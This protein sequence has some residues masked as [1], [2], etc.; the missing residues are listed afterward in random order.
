MTRLPLRLR[1]TATYVALLVVVLALVLGSSW[2]LLHRH[3]ERTLP[4][5]YVDGVME[6]LGS[7]YLLALLGAG[8]LA[9]GVGWAVA[10]SALAPLRRIAQVAR[11]VSDEDLSARVRMEDAPEDEVRELAVAFDAMLDRVAA[12]VAAQQRFV[13]N[14]SHELRTPLTV[15]RTGAEVVLD[16]P[17]ATVEE[18]RAVAREAVETTERTEELLDGLLVLAALGE[19]DAAI[20]RDRVDLGALAS[21]AVAS[22][23]L[24]AAAAGVPFRSELE[25]T[26]VRGDAALLERLVGNLVENAI[27]HGS[28]PVEV[29]LHPARDG[30]RLRVASGGAPIPEADLAR[31]TAPFERLGRGRAGGSGLGLSIVRAVAEAH[32]GTL[33][34]SAPATGGLTAEVL[35]PR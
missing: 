24:E 32:G 10:G 27:R 13:A 16:D 29:E 14:A 3:L 7:Q 21:R 20:A 28:G 11:R 1:L 12:S 22:A 2:V 34:L 17:D 18:L 8:L 25:E 26:P 19:A 4:A 35:L 6:Q 9:L 30:A 33:R 15:I 23:R 31:L 5:P